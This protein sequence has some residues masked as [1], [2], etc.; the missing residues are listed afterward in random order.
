M[1]P[2][3]ILHFPIAKRVQNANG[4]THTECEL[5]SV[6]TKILHDSGRRERGT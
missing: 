6:E 1:M 4:T 2:V 3:P 5:T